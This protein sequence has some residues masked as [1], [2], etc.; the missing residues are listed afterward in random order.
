M[1][2][3]TLSD[4]L[5]TKAHTVYDR[6]V[7]AYGLIPW[8]P[9]RDALR[10]LISTIL[11]HRTKSTDEWAAMDRLW[12]RYGSWEATRDARVEDIARTIRGVTWPEQKAPRI[13]QVLQ[14]ISERRDGDFNLD[15]LAEMPFKEGLA[16]LTSLPGVG[17][18]T[19]SLVLLFNFRKPVLPVD[20]H[21]HRINKRLGLISEKT[22]ADKA[23]DILAELLPRDPDIYWNFHLHLIRHGREVCTFQRPRCT[24]CVL[25]ELCDTYTNKTTG[26]TGELF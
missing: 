4:D 19:A 8:K 18:K 21:L 6:L 22:S 15:F 24:E 14:I 11:S 26:Q 23:H 12:Q 25:A 1:A 16:W 17:I 9:R 2:T 3:H 20:T 5:K 10:E 7:Q 13:Q